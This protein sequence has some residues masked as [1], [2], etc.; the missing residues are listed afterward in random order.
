MVMVIADGQMATTA[1]MG[2]PGRRP[3]PSPRLLQQPRHPGQTVPRAHRLVAPPAQL[4]VVP[5]SILWVALVALEGS[6]AALLAPEASP[7]EPG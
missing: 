6:L 5:W 4:L 7:M 1:Q 3:G 2:N